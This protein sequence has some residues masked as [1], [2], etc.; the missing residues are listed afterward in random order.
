[1]GEAAPRSSAVRHGKLTLVTLIAILGMAV[2]IG[3][4]GNAG[5]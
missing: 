1:M 4:I 2:I 3:F 5:Y